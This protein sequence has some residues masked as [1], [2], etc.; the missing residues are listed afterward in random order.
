[1]NNVRDLPSL[2]L[3]QVFGREVHGRR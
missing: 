1:L 3:L 2:K